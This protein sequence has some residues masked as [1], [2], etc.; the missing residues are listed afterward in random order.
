MLEPER[1]YKKMWYWVFRFVTHV[2][3]RVFFN[4]KVKGLQNIPKKTNFIIAVNHTSYMDP[5]VVSS[6]ISKKIYWIAL[7]GLYSSAWIRWFMYG[8]DTL[9]VGN[10]SEKL[11]CL[12]MD[13]KHVGIFPEGTRTHDGKLRDFKRGAALLAIRTGRPIVPCAIIGAYEAYPV[14]ARFPKFFGSITIKIGPP[15]YL[16]KEFEDQIDDI[17]LQEGTFKLRNTIKEMLD[18]G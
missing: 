4:L 3:M 11:I 8:T 6:V 5:F 10:A 1:Y 2:A 17:V 13:N 12:L 7:K 16:L 9:P 14:K 18:A 15:Q